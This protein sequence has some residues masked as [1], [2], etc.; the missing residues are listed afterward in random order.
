MYPH[1][2]CILS[3]KYRPTYAQKTPAT[4]RGLSALNFNEF[5][6]GT[7]VCV[8]VCIG[9][10]CVYDRMSAASSQSVCKSPRFQRNQFVC[11]YIVSFIGL[12]LQKRPIISTQS[13]CALGHTYSG[14]PHGKRP[15]HT[16]KR[17]IDPQKRPATGRGPFL[18]APSTQSVCAPCRAAPRVELGKIRLD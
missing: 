18:R 7:S 16:Q 10:F 17:P 3:A 6:S 11:A 8:C 1:K 13:V 12:F 9:L 4:A 14:K 2:I 5:I 15:I